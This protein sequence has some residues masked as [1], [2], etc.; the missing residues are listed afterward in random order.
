MRVVS[1]V[2]NHAVSS[3]QANADTY[4]KQASALDER[5][6]CYNTTIAKHEQA[7]TYLKDEA[8]SAQAAASRAEVALEYL[9]AEH[10]ALSEREAR[11][12]AEREA[13]RREGV[14]QAVLMSNLDAIKASL[15]RVEVEGESRVSIVG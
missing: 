4:K 14:G 6:R 10:R 12:G 7:L 15:E 5:N 13:A 9:R 2:S 8:L 11:M 3:L 1:T